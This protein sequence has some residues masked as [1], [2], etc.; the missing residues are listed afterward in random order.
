MGAAAVYVRLGDRGSIRLSS[1]LR[2]YKSQR[3]TDELQAILGK[4]GR[5]LLE[6]L[7]RLLMELPQ[8]DPFVFEPALEVVNAAG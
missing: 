8:R 1:G 4:I 5:A 3:F 2:A 6:C 7:E